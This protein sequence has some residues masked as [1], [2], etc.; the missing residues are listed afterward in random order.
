MMSNIYLKKIVLTAIVAISVITAQA[1]I[2]YN[3]GTDEVRKQ[4]V[5]QYPEIIQREKNFDQF[6]QTFSKAN[7]K[8]EG[9]TY[10]IPVVFHVI[11]D[12]G[13]E[14]IS[15]EQ[16]FEAMERINEDFSK[17][18]SDLAETVAEFFDISAD[19]GIEFRLAQRELSGTCTNGIDRIASMRTYTGGDAAKLGGWQHGFYLNIWVVKFLPGTAAAYAYYPTA[20]SDF[21][22]PVDGIICRYDYVGSTGAAGPYSAH[23]ISHEIGHYFNLQHAWGNTNAP[24]VECGDDQVPD[25]PETK[26]W[27]TCNLA[28]HTCIAP[29]DNVQ[30]FM[31]YSYCS[32]MFTEGQKNRMH[33]ALNSPDAAR[34]NLWIEGT[35]M[36]TGTNDGYVSQPCAPVADFYAINRMVCLGESVTFHDVSWKGI[37]DMRTWT[38]EG[39][40][41][42]TSTEADP[43]VTFAETGWHKVTL[44]VNNA[45][46]SN[47]KMVDQYIYVSNDNPIL[48]ST[49]FGNF[50]DAAEVAENWVLYNKYP[51]DYV[52]QWRGS[53]GYYNTGCIWLNSRFGPDAEKDEAIS[54]SFNLSDGLAENVFFKYSTTSYATAEADYDMALKVYYSTNCGKTWISVGEITGSELISSY[55][56]ASNFFPTETEQWRSAVFNLPAGA[57]NENVKFKLEFNYN[58]YVNNIFIDDFNFTTGV[59]DVNNQHSVIQCSVSPNPANNASAI[60]L[61]YYLQSDLEC[62]I[63]IFDI[64]G[65]SIANIPM[66]NQIAGNHHFIIPSEDIDLVPGMYLIQ[67]GNES[68]R[69][70]KELIIL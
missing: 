10:I 31:E 51:D 16:I 24:G 64:T 48:N 35:L 13:A 26:G 67:L 47:D 52:W 27:T 49:Y 41:P 60:A 54:P 34:N 68:I 50:N 42:A 56:G 28:G 18:N 1:Q 11:H 15:D 65:K 39:G 25:T 3:C 46:G 5:E 43:I 44:S 30:N 32:T 70:I 36:L 55:G 17:S 6:A 37:V 8:M 66:G 38:F 12:Y 21:L 53:N 22:A 29:L 63:T 4:L 14:N 58:N 9:S 45:V 62:S 33:A 20:I 40:S 69:V 2:S 59:L 19:C 61:D 7:L 57:Q 23:T